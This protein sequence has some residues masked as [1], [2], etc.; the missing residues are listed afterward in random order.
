MN[1]YKL[2]PGEFVIM[3]TDQVRFGDS[4]YTEQLDELVLSNRNII[5]VA[6]T[7][8]GLFRRTSKTYKLPLE[9]IACPNGMP[10][11]MALK[12]GGECHVQVVFET[13]T[14]SF[15]FSG[16]RK[17]TAERWADGIRRAAVGDL[18]RIRTEDSA[19]PK[20]LLDL[21]DGAKQVFGAVFA[22]GS[23][24]AGGASAMPSNSAPVQKAKKPPMVSRKCNGCHAPLSGREGAVVT[25]EYCGMKQTL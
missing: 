5:I 7:S 23:A 2:E 12:R 11:V 19:M 3:Q 25:C 10:Q 9:C 24:V 16:E 6:S 22:G 1:D 17:R 21:A 15:G 4:S 18:A 8:A 14:I 13:E 20:E